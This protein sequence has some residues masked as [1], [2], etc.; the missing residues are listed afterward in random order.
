MVRPILPTPCP[1][2]ARVL[3]DRNPDHKPAPAPGDFVICIYCGQPCVL[4]QDMRLRAA[5]VPEVIRM[6]HNELERRRRAAGG[7]G[8]N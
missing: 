1:G 4:L 5:T 2:C 6:I 3:W 8:V 7:K